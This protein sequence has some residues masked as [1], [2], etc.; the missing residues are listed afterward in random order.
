MGSR[1]HNLIVRIT[2]GEKASLLKRAGSLVLSDY[3]RM[4]LFPHNKKYQKLAKLAR[5]KPEPT[6]DLTALL[7]EAPKP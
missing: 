4:V 2:S 3:I 7:P 1:K 5:V 6:T